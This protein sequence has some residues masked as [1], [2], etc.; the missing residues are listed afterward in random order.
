MRLSHLDSPATRHLAPWSQ[1]LWGWHIE[2]PE[3][4]HTEVAS[5]L[6]VGTGALATSPQALGSHQAQLRET[7]EGRRD[8]SK[9]AEKKKLSVK[10]ELGPSSRWLSS[11]EESS[12]RKTA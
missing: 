4:R 9:G 6:P 7:E 1:P 12:E 2:H 11:S 5:A 3:K 10:P 8:H